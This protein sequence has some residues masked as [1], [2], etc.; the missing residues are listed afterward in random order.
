LFDVSEVI[1]GLFSTISSTTSSFKS[2]LL[3]VKC[4]SNIFIGDCKSTANCRLFAK[5]S[6]NNFNTALRLIAS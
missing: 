3:I 6:P 5:M 4:V 2:L 1:S